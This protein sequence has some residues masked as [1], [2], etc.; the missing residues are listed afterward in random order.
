M[1]IEHEGF[2]NPDGP[3]PAPEKSNPFIPEPESELEQNMQ[4]YADLALVKATAS[5]CSVAE[6]WAT[7]AHGHAAREAMEYTCRGGR[8]APDDDEFLNAVD[9]TAA[10]MVELVNERTRFTAGIG[11]SSKE[12]ERLYGKPSPKGAKGKAWLE[13]YVSTGMSESDASV[14][15]ALCMS[16]G[17]K[18]V[19]TDIDR[20]LVVTTNLGARGPASTVISV[21]GSPPR[22]F[23]TVTWFDSEVHAHRAGRFVR[24]APKTT[25][26]TMVGGVIARQ[27]IK[28]TLIGYAQ[29]KGAAFGMWTHPELAN[30]LKPTSETTAQAAAERH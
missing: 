12:I 25:S 22:G 3:L 7:G 13:W 27:P 10:R 29:D 8:L 2:W 19:P 17:R 9:C 11:R 15:L 30:E 4:I 16:C 26:P 28:Q 18:P 23:A 1:N 6:V 20:P 24:V 5:G 14:R 21:E